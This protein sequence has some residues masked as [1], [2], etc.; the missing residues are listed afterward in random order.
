MFLIA[1]VPAETVTSGGMQEF[2]SSIGS[3]LTSANLW[4]EVGP[5]AAIVAVLVLFKLGY[6]VL[7]KN[8]NNATKPNGKAMQ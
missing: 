1:E 2:V 5:I 8:V 4:A 7:K 6:N 3:T